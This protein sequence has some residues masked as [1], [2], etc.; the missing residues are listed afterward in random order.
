MGHQINYYTYDLD[1]KKQDI[2]DELNEEAKYSSDSRSCLPNPIRWLDVTLDDYDTAVQYIANHERTWY[3][4]VAV[5]YKQYPRESTSK[6]AIVLKDRIKKQQDSL[7]K[8][9]RDS[10]VSNRTSEYIGCEKCGSKLKR[11][12]LR[13]DCCPLCGKDLRSATN[14]DR[15]KN[16]NDKLADLR[17]KLAEQIKKDTKPVVKWLVKIEYH[18]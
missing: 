14:L 18:T 13:G 5:K 11:T 8:I 2:I 9:V 10:H 12:L 6:A 7:N 4:Q 3:D 15:I 1:C 17:D 16:A